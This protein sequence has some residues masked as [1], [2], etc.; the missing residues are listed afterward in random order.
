MYES[1]VERLA[2]TK[3]NF[4]FPNKD[5]S[6]A[7]I[8]VSTLIK[9]ANEVRFFVKNLDGSIGDLKDGTGSSR[10]LCALKDFLEQGKIMKMVIE[11]PAQS[12]EE[13]SQIFQFLK[14]ASKAY[15]TLDIR[16]A[17]KAF[18]DH[19]KDGLSVE[20]DAPDF[21]YMIGDTNAYRVNFDRK[22]HR[23]VCNFNNEPL[24]SVIVKNFDAYFDKCKKVEF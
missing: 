6:H 8:V 20:G 1:A 2:S 19:Q 3:E 13:K 15:E 16:Q 17:T 18:V 7:S 11:D 23:A 12:Q 4:D 9:Y 5:N 21:Y 22:N 24:A 14:D 10:F